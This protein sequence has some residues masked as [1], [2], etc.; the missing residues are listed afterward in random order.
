MLLED[1]A[2]YAGLLLAPAKGFGLRPK[3]FFALRAKKKLIM[4][5]PTPYRFEPSTSFLLQ[6][7]DT[8]RYAGLLLAPAVGFGFRPMA[9]FALCAK[10]DR[11]ILFWTILGNLWCPVV[12]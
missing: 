5:T 4:L 1:T 2:H 9:F 7:E 3:A 8:A 6:L 10:K 12:T 11:F